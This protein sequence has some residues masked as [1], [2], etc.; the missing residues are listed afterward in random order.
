MSGRLWKQFWQLLLILVLLTLLL[1]ATGV[2]LR[3]AASFYQQGEWPI[4]RQFPWWLL[5]K[6]DRSL[7]GMLVTIWVVIFLLGFHKESFVKWRRSAIF[8]ILLMALGPGL[9][10]N[11]IFKSHWGRP[12]PKDV[13]EFGGQKKFLQPW[14]KGISGEGRSFPSGHA[15]SGFYIAASWFVF[16]RGN[17]LVA[18][19]W[20]YGGLTF[21]ILMSV[22]RLTQGAHF[23]T[24]CLWSFGI[25]WM[26]AMLL[27]MRLLQSASTEP[28]ESR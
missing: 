27:D 25:V 22:S 9:T 2:D 6:C 11:A 10:V 14:Q 7:A 21:G 8:M 19:C 20:L 26:I 3:V 17:R 1:A 13:Q 23:V 24:D 5:Y 4:G 15:A 16:R 18:R 12:R 28:E